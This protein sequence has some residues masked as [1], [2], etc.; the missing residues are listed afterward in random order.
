MR[1]LSKSELVQTT[2]TLAGEREMVLASSARR[3]RR[4]VRRAA[5]LAFVAGL[6]IGF[7]SARFGLG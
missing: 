2:R 5:L 3:W 7:W 1:Q 4:V 6:V